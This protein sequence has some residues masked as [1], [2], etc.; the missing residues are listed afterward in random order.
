MPTPTADQSLEVTTMRRVSWRLM[1]FLL[2]AYLI[3]Y[4]D[5]VNVGFAALQMNKA[6]GIDT[7]TYGLGAGIFFV[8]YFILEVPSNLALERFGARTWIAR[9]MITWGLVSAAFALI[10]GP[11]SFLVLRFLLGAAEAGFFPGV[12]LYITYWYPAQYRAIIVGIFMVAIPVAGLIGSPVSGAILYM[13]GLLGLGGW[14]WIFLLEA[15]PAILL[16]LGT[17]VWL[18]DRPEQASWLTSEQQQWLIAKLETERRRAPRISHTSV[19]R[20]ISNKY[21]LI[22][23][24]VYS[25]AAGASVALALWMPQLVKSFG[26]TN[27]QTGLLNAVPFGIAAVWMILWGRSSDRS[28]E[29]VWHNALPLGW[30]VLAMLATFFAIKSLWGMIPLLTL[31]AAGTYASKGP[32]WALSSEWL[33]STSA[34][35][36]LAQI[37]ALG[38]L[39]SF[40]FSYLIG[41]IVTETGSFPLGLMPIALVSAIGT[42]S[43][44]VIGRRQPRTVAMT[45]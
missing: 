23:A 35:A 33:G 24:L 44:V 18:T 28:G 12:I 21:V 22:M 32:F 40:G 2:L 41:W 37:N 26:L 39:A 38:N 25:G 14:Q 15:A 45:A 16:G 9:I 13:D 27:W 11:I 5:R 3:C 19:W 36:G 6:V 30:M 8:G 4:I 43:V 34:A 7:K 31:I 29:R 17:F 1:P 10:G 42:V 20:V